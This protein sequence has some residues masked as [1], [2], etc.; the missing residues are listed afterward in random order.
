MKP[1]AVLMTLISC[2]GAFPAHSSDQSGSSGASTDLL[3]GRWIGRWDSQRNSGDMEIEARIADSGEIKGQIRATYST[4]VR[5]CSTSWEVL[6]GAKKG[7]ALVVRY[8]LKGACGRVDAILSI[9][10]GGVMIGKW[11]NESGGSG[12]FRLLKQ[13]HR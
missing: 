13:G 12:S 5:S 3:T 2:I 4:P 10:R 9:D 8:D 6:T 1:L 7:E 11:S